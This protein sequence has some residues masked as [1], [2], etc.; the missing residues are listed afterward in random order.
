MA[1]AVRNRNANTARH[2]TLR[3]HVLPG[4]PIAS[5]QSIFLIAAERLDTKSLIA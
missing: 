5:L 4:L 3:I 2:H 1:G